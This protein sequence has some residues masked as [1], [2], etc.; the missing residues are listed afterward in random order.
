MKLYISIFCML[1][2]L[3]LSAQLEYSLVQVNDSIFDDYILFKAK[4]D[5]NEFLMVIEKQKWSETNQINDEI[6]VYIADNQDFYPKSDDVTYRFE[7]MIIHHYGEKFHL[8]DII[9]VG[10][11][12]VY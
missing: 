3:Q 10:K 8:K 4:N 1:I 6:H 7:D 5:L 9:V 11:L 12:T 2:S